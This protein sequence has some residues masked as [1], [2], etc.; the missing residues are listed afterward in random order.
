MPKLSAVSQRLVKGS[1]IYL[2]GLFI[3]NI[4]NYL[5]SIL[6]G[7]LL[8]PADFGE[9]TSLIS[10]L[11]IVTVPG[12]AVWTLAMKFAADF[13]AEAEP[14]A[15]HGLL[16]SLTRWLGIFGGLAVLVVIG[17][18]QPLQTFL[19]LHDVRPIWVVGAA[20]AV[21][22]LVQANRGILQGR[23][24]FMAANISTI[25]ESTLKL[26]LGILLV[27]LG[28]R[29]FGATL[30]ILL[31]LLLSYG[32]TFLPLRS[33]LQ[34]RPIHVSRR[35]ILSYSVPALLAA[36]CFSILQ[37]ADIIV[38]KHFF[39]PNEAGLYAALSNT[40]KIAFYLA[41]PV[42]A[43]M[44]PLIVEQNHRQ[45]RHVGLLILTIVLSLLIALLVLAIFTLAPGLVIRLLYGTAYES[46]FALL[47]TMGVA[48]A[49]LL[50]INV[51]IQYFLAVETRLV[52]LGLTG[53]ATALLVFLLWFNH[54]SLLV[55]VRTV[56][57]GYGVALVLL[58]LTYLMNKRG[59]LVAF[60]RGL[61]R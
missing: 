29:V 5:Y 49:A 14:G 33:I 60:A 18:S 31:A 51:F 27:W 44:F 46:V 8:G 9:V 10:L 43:V 20:I 61:L 48:F 59:P 13:A 36:L 53:L 41:A 52:Y 37:N 23:Q 26:I 24:E 55:V 3:V 54:P 17:L 32:F 22:L 1:A 15:I 4:A 40:G 21:T 2:G 28:L 12:V 39:T 50:L 57:F 19:Q 25:L 47:P 42:A 45:E 30:A 11:V 7:R 58:V 34:V 35:S 6:M 56:L 16:K 38:V